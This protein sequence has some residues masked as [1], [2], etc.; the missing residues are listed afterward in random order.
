MVAVDG[1]QQ[2]RVTIRTFLQK[3]KPEDREVTTTK[4]HRRTTRLRDRTTTKN[5]NTQSQKRE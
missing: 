3:V 5:T 1:S 4:P 2:P